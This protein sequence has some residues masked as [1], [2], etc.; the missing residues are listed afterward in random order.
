MLP[1]AF[2]AR[3]PFTF[4]SIVAV[5]A[6][7]NKPQLSHDLSPSVYNLAMVSPMTKLN[8]FNSIHAIL[9]LLTWPLSRIPDQD[10]TFPLSATLMH[11]G[12]TIGLHIPLS[13]I[14]FSRHKLGGLSEADIQHRATLWAQCQIAYARCS[15]CKGVTAF[16]I[17]Q[18]INNAV[19]ASKVPP[20][21]RFHRRLHHIVLRFFEASQEISLK[22][23]DPE[24]DRS[25]GVLIGVFEDQ[26]RN[27][28][29]EQFGGEFPLLFSR[30]HI[31]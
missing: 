1:N 15:I 2:Y 11:M 30:N 7:K 6:Q 20:E 26:L 17:N 22:K 18:R 10:I 5:A 25:L 29:D 4:F 14:E 19:I 8:Y 12:L 23:M 28:A 24:Q 3:D 27:V 9:L 13:T 16:A 21:L 31:G